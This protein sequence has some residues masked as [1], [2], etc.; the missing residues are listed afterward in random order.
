MVEE[1]KELPVNPQFDALAER[2]ILGQ[3][4]IAPGEVR[5]SQRVAPQVSE[6]TILRGI[7]AHASARAWI[8]SRYESIRVQPLFRARLRDPI[9]GIA[10]IGRHAGNPAGEL[11]EVGIAQVYDSVPIRRIT[12][13][14]A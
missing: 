4:E 3:V 2:E 6:L 13:A 5:S 9:D 10:F 7:T 14:Q 1:V 8:Y 11:G 12:G